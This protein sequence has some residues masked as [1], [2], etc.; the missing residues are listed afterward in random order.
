MN[1]SVIK[2][3]KY[4]LFQRS[5]HPENRHADHKSSAHRS[6]IQI[7]CEYKAKKSGEQEQ[8]D[9]PEI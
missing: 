8:V 1:Q 2:P 6:T 5:T 4:E 3:Q 9:K 7:F